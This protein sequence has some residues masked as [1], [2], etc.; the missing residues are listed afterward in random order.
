MA[1]FKKEGAIDINQWRLFRNMFVNKFTAADA[2]K[3]LFLNKDEL[4]TSLEDIPVLAKFFEDEV[5]FPQLLNDISGRADKEDATINFFEWMFI[6]QCAVAWSVASGQQVSISKT[7]L[8]DIGMKVMPHFSA[9][10]G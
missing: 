7:E 2:D 8:L 9:Y 1:D 3:N 10:E 5:A 6:R 4:K